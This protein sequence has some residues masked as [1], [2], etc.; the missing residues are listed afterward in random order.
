MFGEFHQ[1][2]VSQEC[3]EKPLVLGGKERIPADVGEKFLGGA[4]GCLK[5]EP[6]FDIAPEHIGDFREKEFALTACRKI[7]S[8]A[9][10]EALNRINENPKN[11]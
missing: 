2:A 6:V 1:V 10:S 4:P 3:H 5:A 11:R 8:M 7:L 9:S